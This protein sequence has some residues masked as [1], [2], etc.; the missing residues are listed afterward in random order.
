MKKISA[1][2]AIMLTAVLLCTA[3][4]GCTNKD[5]D[6]DKTYVSMDINPSVN[7]VIDGEGKVESVEAANE[8]A[9]VMLYGEVLVGKTAEEAFELIANLAIECGYLTEENSGVNVT[10]VAGNGSAEAEANIGETVKAA[11]NAEAGKA[12]NTGEKRTT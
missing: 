10:V 4:V 11:F 8:D 12:E 3:F 2:I 9:Q 1:I 6:A 5:K 7:L